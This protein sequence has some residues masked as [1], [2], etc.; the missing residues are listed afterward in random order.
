[1][2]AIGPGSLVKSVFTVELLHRTQCSNCGKISE[3]TESVVDLGLSVP[4]V[5]EASGRSVTV[6]GLLDEYQRPVSMDGHNKYECESITCRGTRQD[7]KRWTEVARAPAHLFLVM[8][9][10]SFSIEKSEYVKGHTIVGS[11]GGKELTGTEAL[12]LRDLTYELYAAVVHEVW[13]YF[14]E[15]MYY[16]VKG[17]TAMKGHYVAVGRRSEGG[18]SS[19]WVKYDDSTVTEMRNNHEV[20]FSKN[21]LR[22]IFSRI[23]CILANISS[24]RAA[25]LG[26]E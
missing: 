16:Y 24:G 26:C 15:F 17:G 2:D 18:V 14:F 1:M 8:N 7:A 5:S 3:R 12:R 23:D 25:P 10:F 4:K 21:K 19:S 22:K 13:M 11:S 6:Q 9:R 20:K